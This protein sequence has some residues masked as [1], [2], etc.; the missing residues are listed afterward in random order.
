[1]SGWLSIAASIGLVLVAA[2]SVRAQTEGDLKAGDPAPA[3]KLEGSDGRTYSLA[4]F[5]G[6]KAVV[7]AWFPKAFTGG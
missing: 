5:K 2:A 4:D 3:F 7:L 6:K 1:M